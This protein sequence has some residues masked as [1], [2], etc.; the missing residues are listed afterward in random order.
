MCGGVEVQS[1][2]FL[3]SV[4]DGGEWSVSFPTSLLLGKNPHW[5]GCCVGPKAALNAVEKRKLSCPCQESNTYSSVIQ[6]I[7]QSLV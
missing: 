2:E 3:T 1:H 5:I 7:F 4:L 6:P